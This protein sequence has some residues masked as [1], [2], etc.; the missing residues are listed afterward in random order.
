[1]H[2]IEQIVARL[3]VGESNRTVI[4]RV[5]S[6]LERGYKT[7]RQAS[8]KDRRELLRLIIMHHA[9]NRKLYRDVMRGRL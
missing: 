9:R 3:H 4:R 2:I 5:I 8:R 6:R 7:Y 1:M